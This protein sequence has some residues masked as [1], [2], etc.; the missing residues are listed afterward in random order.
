LFGDGP[1]GWEGFELGGDYGAKGGF[2]AS[3]MAYAAADRIIRECSE[4]FL[5]AIG[6][7]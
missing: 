2:E 1:L 6:A 5:V 3:H 7:L 4:A